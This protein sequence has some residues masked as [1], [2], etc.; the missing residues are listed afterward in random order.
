MTDV[1]IIGAGPAG[2]TAAIYA[3]R[4]GVSVQV[5]ERS[6][7]GGQ[8][9]LT[10]EVDNFPSRPGMEG[11]T[12]ASDLYAH[13]T[14]HGTEVLF[15]EVSAVELEG[16]VKKVT[17]GGKT[18]EGRAVIIA[19]GALR[20]KLGVPGE[21][22]FAG[23]GVSYCA[24][25]DAA[26]FKDKTVA[27]VGGGDTALGDA[28]FLSNHCKKVYLIHRRDEFRAEMIKQT[29]VR[30]R[31]NVEIVTPATVAAVE[32]GDVVERLQV[33]TPEGR[34]VIEVDGIFVA[35]GLAPDTALYQ[36][37][38]PMDEIGYF[39][40]AEDCLTP[41][42]GVFVAGDCRQKPL[43]QIVTAAADGAVAA[44]AAAEYCNALNEQV[45]GAE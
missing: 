43:R 20:R 30:A 25:C 15:D 21:A 36:G 13:A 19:G 10:A 23:R 9:S 8:V 26:F 2:L 29:A 34:R 1:M 45:A 40:A 33:D 5:F 14:A 44:V 35:I 11:V 22:E 31:E 38:L 24:T 3:A 39:E 27:I 16:A 41:L 4:A 6:L 7:Y 42:P 18:H 17:A 12:F 28:L 32:G 37:R